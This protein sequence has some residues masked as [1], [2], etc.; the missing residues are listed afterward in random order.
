VTNPLHQVVDV[1]VEVDEH[2]ANEDLQAGYILL[3]VD[4]DSRGE[5]LFVLGNTTKPQPAA[6][7]QPAAAQ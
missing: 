6:P 7:A 4:T 1:V 3:H 2:A 5:L